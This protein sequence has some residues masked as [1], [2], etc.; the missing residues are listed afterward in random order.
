MLS[1]INDGKQWPNKFK[2]VI[3][4]TALLFLNAK[5]G[6]GNAVTAIVAANY[7]NGCSGTFICFGTK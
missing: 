6:K 3:H 4:D 7:R 5:S 2:P 1:S